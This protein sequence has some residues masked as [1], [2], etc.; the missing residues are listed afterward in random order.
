MDT[1]IFLLILATLIAQWRGRHRLAGVLF[2]ASC[3]STALLFWHHATDA[4]GLSL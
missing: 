4:L 3:L 2:A 1:L